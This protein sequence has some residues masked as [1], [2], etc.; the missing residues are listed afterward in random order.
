[1]S[2]LRELKFETQEERNGLD[3]TLLAAGCERTETRETISDDEERETDLCAGGDGT[4]PV[5]TYRQ[6]QKL[7]AVIWPLNTWLYDES[8]AA[9][10]GLT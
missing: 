5:V 3:E 9:M 8:V 6:G 2:Y 10:L 7:L 1:M 4:V